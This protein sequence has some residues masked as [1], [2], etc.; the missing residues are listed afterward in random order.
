MRRLLTATLT[1]LGL[2]LAACGAPVDEPIDDPVPGEEASEDP[3]IDRSDD[4]VADDTDEVT[5]GAQLELGATCENPQDGY[6]ID[7]PTA[8]HVNDGEVTDPCRVLDVERPDV[9]PHTVLPLA[10]SVLLLVEDRDLDEMRDLIAADPA[11]DIDE[12][13]E[14]EIDG[15]T[16]LRVDGTATGEAYLDAGVEVHRTYVEFD[17][18]TLIARASQLGEP[19]LEIR[20][21]VIA[22][23][24]ATLQPIERERQDTTPEQEGSTHD[25]HT[26]S[27]EAAEDDL[28]IIAEA[29]REAR[30][31]GD[32]RADLI[33]V[34]IGHHGDFARLTLEFEDVVPSYEVA[35]ADGPILAFPSGEDLELSGEHYLEVATS[36]TRVDLTGT[37]AVETYDG[38]LRLDGPGSPVVEVAMAGDHHGQ[39][40]WVL[41][42]D[43]AAHFAVGD[44]EDPARI[45][46]DIVDAR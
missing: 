17:G 11:T 6:R 8:W 25:E 33:D 19:E 24:L 42:L 26:T 30:S 9:D 38:P 41:G 23:M 45:V 35:P 14:D 7:Y 12:L 13:V 4:D 21:E 5:L 29:G 46:I 40:T 22:D 37:E 43:E 20:R 31:G 18:R 28:A 2:L 32:G 44:L 39:M 3:S 15:R 34:R 27:D 36:G 10:S 1:G 16:A